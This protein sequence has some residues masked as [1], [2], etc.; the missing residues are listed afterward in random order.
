MEC[1]KAYIKV[2]WSKQGEG[3]QDDEE[4]VLIEMDEQEK[5]RVAEIS[6]LEELKSK[7]IFDQDEM[8]RNFQ[9]VL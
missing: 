4:E 6:E 9:R 7:L 3:D 1:K 2:R 5:L 8:R